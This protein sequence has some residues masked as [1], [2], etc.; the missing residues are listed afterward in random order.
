MCMEKCYES[1]IEMGGNSPQ[2]VVPDSKK[3]SKSFVEDEEE[4]YEDM[5]GAKPGRK[6]FSIFEKG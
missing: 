6:L 4:L 1:Y 2:Y 5:D 3:R